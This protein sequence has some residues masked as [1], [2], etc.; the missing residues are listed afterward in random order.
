MR[1]FDRI[2]FVRDDAEFEAKHDRD[3]NGRFSSGGSSG[4]TASDVKTISRKRVT[5]AVSRARQRL[6]NGERPETVVQDAAREICGEYECANPDVGGIVRVSSPFVRESRKFLYKKGVGK[7][8]RLEIAERQIAVYERI[9]D[10]LDEGKSSGWTHSNTHHPEFD[11][12]TLYR[13][14]PFKGKNRIFS[15]D[16]RR[17]HLEAQSAPDVYSATSEGNPGFELKK[18]KL[19]MKDGEPILEVI[20]AS[21]L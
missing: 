21:M 8:E 4:E 20:G 16:I 3:E 19:G 1:F 2:S 18:K 5:G 13:R 17:P 14:F 11:F 12:C 6:S 7:R 10:L 9:P 15:V